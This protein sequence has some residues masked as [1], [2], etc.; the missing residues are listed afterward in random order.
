MTKNV[1]SQGNLT[2]D[3]KQHTI[4]RFQ[5]KLLIFREL[6]TVYLFFSFV[7]YMRKDHGFGFPFFIFQ[8][9]FVTFL[10]IVNSPREAFSNFSPKVTNVNLWESCFK[11]SC[12]KFPLKHSL[13]YQWMSSS[14]GR[15]I[16]V[17]KQLSCR[18]SW[19]ASEMDRH[20]LWFCHLC[21]TCWGS[22]SDH[23]L[24]QWEIFGMLVAQY[25]FLEHR[26]EDNNKS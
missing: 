9:V 13:D 14:T 17:K 18:S 3:S 5:R 10:A 21:Q 25:A 4:V 12:L 6:L 15:R 23:H 2:I 19:N 7:W 11:R 26:W 20:E 24:R 1:I 16:V 8:F 22:A